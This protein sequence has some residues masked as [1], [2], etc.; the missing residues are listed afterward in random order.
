M[1]DYV[2]KKNYKDLVAQSDLLRKKF[3]EIIEALPIEKKEELQLCFKEYRETQEEILAMA[4]QEIEDVEGEKD[5]EIEELRDENR[6]LERKIDELE[7][8]NDPF[9]CNSIDDQ[10]KMEL[11]IA[12][13]KKYTLT[14]LEERLG[15]NKFQLM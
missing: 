6:D 2:Y 9:N 14:E 11:L 1:A 10:M 5:D 8:S 12:A 15:G 3:S 13:M 7:E 4:D